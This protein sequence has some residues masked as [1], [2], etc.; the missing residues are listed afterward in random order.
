MDVHKQFAIVSIY[1]SKKESGMEFIYAKTDRFQTTPQGLS[2]L[3]TYLQKFSMIV[4][5]FEST[6]PYSLLIYKTLQKFLPKDKILCVNPYFA[7]A[8]PEH[9]SD[10][11]DSRN[12]AKYAF[13]GLVRGSYIPDT[14]YQLLRRLT[15][16]RKRGIRMVVNA[17]NRI[18]MILDRAGLRINQEI[19]LF[20]KYGLNLLLSLANGISLQ[21]HVETALPNSHILR[22]KDQLSPFFALEL[23][24]FEQEELQAALMEYCFLVKQVLEYERSLFNFISKPGNEDLLAQFT[25]L[26]SVPSIGEISAFEL[27]AELGQFTRFSSLKQ[28]QSYA[29]LVPTLVESG[30]KEKKERLQK[31]GNRYLRTTLVCCAKTLVF[32]PQRNPDLKAY[33][34]RIVQKNSRTNKK[35]WVELAKKLLRI[36]IAL[37]R[38]GRTFDSLLIG[39]SEKGKMEKESKKRKAQLNFFQKQISKLHTH[40]NF[41]FASLKSMIDEMATFDTNSSRT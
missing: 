20:T 15:R 18:I 41:T 31:R 36:C 12:L 7:K 21:H 13:F 26:T 22:Y 14:T 2:E 17:K 19:N 6:G 9:K 32:L 5:A 29:G 1:S 11:I 16:G 24:P 27:L 8:L 35:I 23:L 37:L 38:S 10:K 28:V 3:T 25:S 40:F 33:I 34:T 4:V 39:S 30:G